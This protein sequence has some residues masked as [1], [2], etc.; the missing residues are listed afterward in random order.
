M[1]KRN[2]IKI[3][4]S[5]CNGCGLCASACAEGAIKIINGKAKLVSET[6]CDG[7]GACIG[8]CPVDALTIEERDVA[9]FDE[10]AVQKHLA[11]QKQPPQPKVDFICLGMMAKKLRDNPP[12]SQSPAVPADSQLNNWPVQ[13][14]LVPPSAPYLNGADLLLVA[15]CVPFAMGD[16]HSRFLTGRTVVIGCPKLDDNNFYADKLADI[17][18]QNKINSLTV[19]HMEVPCCS[20]LTRI[21]TGAI[22][23]STL[24]LAFDDVTISLQGNV[25]KTEIIN[26]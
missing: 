13:L 9:D 21:A 1:A 15:D 16:F 14:K 3:D 23:Q 2:I 22:K 8:H 12:Q 17:L 24:Q 19:L 25:I 11:G 10:Q 20:G 7:L 4:E 26:P 6:Y 18:R 5:K